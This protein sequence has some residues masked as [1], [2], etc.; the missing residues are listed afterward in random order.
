METKCQHLTM[1]QRDD[2]FKLLKKSEELFDGALGT[3][4][5]DPVDFELKEDA[6]KYARDHTQYRRYTRKCS[7]RR[8]EM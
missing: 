5:T 6:I 2:L 1:T 3:R 4:K 7:K 8:L